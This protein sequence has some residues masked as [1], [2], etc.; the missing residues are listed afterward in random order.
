MVLG[1][2]TGNIGLIQRHGRHALLAGGEST[3]RAEY[4]GAGQVDDIRLEVAQGLIDRR[5]RHAHR[6]RIHQRHAHGGHAV[7]G[8]S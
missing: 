5:G 3:R 8:E 6:Q 1:G 2:K 7:D 4:E